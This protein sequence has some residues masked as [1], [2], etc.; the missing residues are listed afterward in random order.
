MYVNVHHKV[1]ILVC[2]L[3]FTVRIIHAC[4][5]YSRTLIIQHKMGN[6]R[7][8]RLQR[9]SDY[10]GFIVKS[11]IMVVSQNMVMEVFDY[12]ACWII[13]VPLCV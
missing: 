13:E 11:I 4:T 7:H 10:G 9:L 2:T 3:Q 1:Y 6:K 12:R 8:V 5:T